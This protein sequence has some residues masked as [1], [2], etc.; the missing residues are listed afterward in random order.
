MIKRLLYLNG[1]AVMTVILYHASAWGFISMFFWT[2]R[3]REVSVPNFDQLGGLTYYGLRAIEQIVIYGIPTFLFVSG[4]F[5]AISTGRTQETI[6]WK[7][8]LNRA[9]NLFIPFLIWSLVILSLKIIQ[10]ERYDI[11][12]MVSMVL[13]GR[14]TDAYY[15]VP[16][17]IQMYLLAPFLVPLARRN[18]KLLL[19]FSALLQG[20]V[21][22]MRYQILLGIEPGLLAPIGFISRSWLFPGFIFW[23]SL[24]L[25]VGLN[26]EVLK[27]VLYRVRWWLLSGVILFFVLG[28]VEW[29]LILQASGKDWIGPRE[30]FVDQVYALFFIFTFL[31]FPDFT[32]PLPNQVES[33]G[34]RSYGIYLV[35]SPVL[36]YT[37]RGVYHLAP[38]LLGYQIVLQPLLYLTGLGLPL[39]LMAIINRS[40]LR[41]NYHLLFGK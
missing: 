31:A 34:K 38:V 40:A 30:T 35:H 23:F 14:V 19:F 3:Y 15:F 8:V 28:M 13:Q 22:F 9:K 24:G 37:A 32:P 29:E 4:F 1:L 5:V 33:L 39:L 20:L 36:E 6:S 7:I 25:V 18:W 21:V 17:L 2:D 12:E 27:P 11:L 26:V 41:K 10:G 16:V